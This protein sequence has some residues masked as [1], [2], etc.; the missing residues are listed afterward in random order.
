[1]IS[2][3]FSEGAAR[4]PWKVLIVEDEASLA[5]VI[6]AYL[7]KEGYQ[8]WSSRDGSEGLK[9]FYAHRP[10]LIILDLMLPSLSGEEI[11]RHIRRDS[12]V[13][14]IMLTAK[15]AEEEKLEGL[16]LG[17]DDYLVKPVSPRE[18]TARVKTILR[19]VEQNAGRVQQDIIRQGPVTVDA[20]SHRVYWT[21]GDDLGE[22]EKIEQEITLTPT[23]Y[24]ILKVLVQ[25][26]RKVFSRENLAEHV[27]GYL[28][29]GDLRTV[30]T[31]IKNLRRK[32]EPDHRNPVFI[33]T[34]FGTGYQWGGVNHLC[35]DENR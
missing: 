26:P 28:W 25:Y 16:G 8:V 32:L 7:E 30:D 34:V 21:L 18:V 4:L 3:T 33:K 20:L 17:A 10:H 2:E 5:K 15:G 35:K 22:G 6:K 12:H 24:Q 14:I 19:R 23:E 29:E 9:M 11:A 1:M 27:F 13:P 31:H